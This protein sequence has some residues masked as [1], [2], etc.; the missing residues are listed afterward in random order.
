M[1]IRNE[2]KILEILDNFVN[3]K[4]VTINQSVEYPIKEFDALRKDTIPKILDVLN[5]LFKKEIDIGSFKTKIDSYNKKY[6]LWGFKGFNGMMFFNMLYKCS[7]D[8]SELHN[9]MIDVLKLP[10]NIYDAKNKIQTLVD[11]I[12]IISADITDKRK[13]P[14]PKSSLFFLSYFWQIQAPDRF[15]VFYQSMEKDFLD[16]QILEKDDNLA[17]YYEKFYNINEELRKLFEKRVNRPVNLWFIEH[18]FWRYHL[19]RQEEPKKRTDEIETTTET[20]K[21]YIPPVIGNIIN[22]SKNESNPADF[23]IA[24][25]KLFTMLGFEVE[26]KGQGRGRTV[27]VIA[28]GYG[29]GMSKPY[30]L[31][32]DCKSRKNADYKIN[33]GDER[34][35]IEYIKSFLYDSPRDRASDIYFLIVSSGFRDIEEKALR[36]I[37]AETNIDTILITI[38]TLL[39]LLSLKLQKWDLDI[40]K[41]K[42]IFQT[43]GIVTKEFI[44]EQLI[45]R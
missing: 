35:I 18:V 21:D 32:V 42:N 13:T 9:L 2:E 4:Q 17:E 22:L 8:K 14:S 44:Q 29:Y 28:R 6:P 10:D 33:A 23:E 27:D 41:M 37:K 19:Q 30:V 1:K 25:G 31:L 24:T 40:E 3:S 20:Y 43:R 7:S 38:E 34:T 36:K 16:L 39:F 12:N 5:M 26:V 15:P 45:G 11:Y